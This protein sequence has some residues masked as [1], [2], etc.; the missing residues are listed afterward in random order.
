MSPDRFHGRRLEF[1][2]LKSGIPTST[3][4]EL[5]SS[6]PSLPP[7]LYMK[8]RNPILGYSKAPWGLSVLSRVTG[9]F[10]GTS[11]SPGTLLRQLPNRYAI[12]AGQ[13]LPDKEFRYLRTVIVTAAVYW[14]FNSMLAHLLLT[15]Q[16]R[17]GV[18]SYTS[19][20]DLAQTCVFGKQLLGPILCGSI[21]GAPLLPKLRGQFAEF[22][23]NPSPVGLRIF[24]LPTCVGLRYGHLRYTRSFSRLLSSRTS[25]LNFPRSLPEPTPGSDL[26]KVSLRLNLSVGTESLPSVH[27]L[28]R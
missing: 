28:R 12:R 15:F 8:Y 18:S 23:N 3:P 27:R 24:F 4:T 14:G 2:H 17:A 5:A 21:S 20:F 19:S 25:V 11:I 26:L 10:T 13:N 22:L 9:I 16:H 1:Q 7:I 6:L